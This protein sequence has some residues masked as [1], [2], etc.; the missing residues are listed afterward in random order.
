MIKR[1]LEILKITNAINQK[2]KGTPPSQAIIIYTSRFYYGDCL[3]Y[4]LGSVLILY[5][6]KRRQIK[7][8]WVSN[9][10]IK[11]GGDLN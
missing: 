6:F 1:Y 8:I 3:D 4:I 10:N 5:P 11:W 2:V 7:R 9:Y